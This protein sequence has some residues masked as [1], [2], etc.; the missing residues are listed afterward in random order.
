MRGYLLAFS[1]LPSLLWAQGQRPPTIVEI[2]PAKV[3]AAV[4]VVQLTGSLRA[5][6]QVA[7]TPE[8]PGRVRKIHAAEGQPV[9]AG[10]LIFTLDRALLG[11]ER[12][13]REAAFQLAQRN[14]NRSQEML[15][16]KLIAQSD[17]DQAKSNLEVSE[18]A[19]QSIRVRL[20]KLEIRAPFAGILGLREVSIGEYVEV[21]RRLT[22]MA[23]IDPIKLDTQVPERNLSALRVGLPVEVQIDALGGER[24]RGELVAMD[25]VV[26]PISRTVAVRAQFPNADRRLKPGMFARVAIELGRR[27]QA[28]WIPEQALVPESQSVF[29]YRVIDGRAQRTEV[30]TGLRKPGYVEIRSGLSGGD[31]VVTAGQM[32]IAE[33]S[34]VS[35]AVGGDGS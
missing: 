8:L 15:N 21:G 31:R 14:Y 2:A 10:A 16:K 26:D 3:E 9:A 27:E 17:Y 30:T 29:V 23:Q 34:A 25:P 28:V 12:A 11:A 33:G 4:V 13:E 1:L 6:E 22:Q 18:A 35:A 5:N 20:S 32:K 24:F 7:I 19:L